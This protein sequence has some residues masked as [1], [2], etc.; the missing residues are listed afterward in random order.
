MSVMTERRTARRYDLTLPIS[1][2]FA[3]ETLVTRQDGRT[4]DISTR[5]LY[6]VV[7]KDLEAGSDLDITLTLPA[8]ITHGGDVLVRAQGKVVRVEPRLEDGE[9]RMGVAAVIERYDIIRSAP[10][11]A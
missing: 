5:G 10:V 9:T 1:I 2:R 7:P 11:R 3:A 6:F 4:R 8:E